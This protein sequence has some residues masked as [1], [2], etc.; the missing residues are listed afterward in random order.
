M[1]LTSR[2]SWRVKAGYGATDLSLLFG[3]VVGAFFLAG[4]GVLVCMPLTDAKHRRIQRLLRRRRA[5]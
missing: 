1:N 5:P 4:C 2:L 3:P